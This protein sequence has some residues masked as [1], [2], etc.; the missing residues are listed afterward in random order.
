MG[1]LAIQKT[2]KESEKALRGSS[3]FG[4]NSPINRRN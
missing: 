3:D 2:E 1:I 4:L